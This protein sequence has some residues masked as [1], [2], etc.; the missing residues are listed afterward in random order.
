MKRPALSSDRENPGEEGMHVKRANQ[1]HHWSHS[2]SQFHS[3][4]IEN[5]N[6]A[7]SLLY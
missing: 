4:R 3:F 1:S 2:Q 6:E 7:S 5:G